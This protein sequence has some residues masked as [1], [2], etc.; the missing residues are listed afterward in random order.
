M[1]GR[2]FRVGE[3]IAALIDSMANIDDSNPDNGTL[4]DTTVITVL[5]DFG[6]GNWSQSSGFN[7]EMGSDHQSNRDSTCFQCIP[8][9]GG[10]LPG[11]KVLGSVG[12]DGSPTA[13]SET[14]TTQQILSTVLDLMGMPY[15]GFYP[16]AESLVAKLS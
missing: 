3:A 4:L 5:T 8:I 9:I 6:R 7:T 12:G 1:R 16:D 14:F 2:A 13:G 10:G 11:T 15:Q